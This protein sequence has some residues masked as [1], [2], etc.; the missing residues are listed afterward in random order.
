MFNPSNNPYLNSPAFIQNPFGNVGI[1]SKPTL[2]LKQ[3]D[4]FNPVKEFI[5]NTNTKWVLI[6]SSTDST[7]D[8]PNPKNIQ[9]ACYWCSEYPDDLN[10]KIYLYIVEGVK[11]PRV[12]TETISRIMYQWF[13]IVPMFN[14]T[15][16]M[17]TDSEW[18]KANVYSAPVLDNKQSVINSICYIRKNSTQNIPT[19]NSLIKVDMLDGRTTEGNT[20]SDREGQ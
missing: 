14:F 20:E 17:I 11:L 9:I 8:I 15:P 3:I 12:E 4:N 18:L 2:Q 13:S 19:D 10:P 1:V 6:K 7:I 5:D 16:Q